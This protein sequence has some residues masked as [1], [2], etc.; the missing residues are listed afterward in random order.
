MGFEDFCLIAI[1]LTFYLLFKSGNII[2]CRS[3]G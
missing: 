1:C 2:F 3:P